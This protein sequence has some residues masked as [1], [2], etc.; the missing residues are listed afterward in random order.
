MFTKEKNVFNDSS[1]LMLPK[2]SDPEIFLNTLRSL[3]EKHKCIR[4]TVIGESIMGRPICAVTLGS[5]R[6]SRGV[7]FAGGMCGDDRYSPA[8]LLRFIRDYAEF[9]ESGKRICSVS[10]PYLYAN[11][12]IHVIPMLNPDGYAIRKHGVADIPIRDRLIAMNGSE[13]FSAWKFNARGVDLAENFTELSDSP[14]RGIRAESEPE[15]AA[16]CSYIR[17]AESG[18]FGKIELAMELHGRNSCIRRSKILHL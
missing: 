1:G 8:V 6:M 10:I 13:D 7:L 4:S 3:E 16:L 14:N 2:V 5:D 9:L 11:R 18:I 12:C 15:T 17:M